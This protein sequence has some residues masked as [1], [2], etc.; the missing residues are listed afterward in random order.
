VPVIR[1][2]QGAAEAY[3]DEAVTASL[4]EAVQRVLDGADPVVWEERSAT[5]KQDVA[6]R[7]DQGEVVA[8]WVDLA[9]GRLAEARGRF[10]AYVDKS[11][12]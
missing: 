3:G 8:A 12:Q 2:W 10:A 9:Y 11:L 4:G 5:A 7:F 6:N 1:G